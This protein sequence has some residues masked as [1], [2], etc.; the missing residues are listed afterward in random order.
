MKNKLK[1]SDIL[2]QNNVKFLMK[3]KKYLILASSATLNSIHT[4]KF[5]MEK[6]KN[7]KFKKIVIDD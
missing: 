4:F 6:Q 1:K 2:I 3:L 5:K 7:K